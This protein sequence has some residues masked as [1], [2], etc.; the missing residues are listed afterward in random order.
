MLAPFLIRTVTLFGGIA[1][2]KALSKVLPVNP[3]MFK[4]DPIGT[5]GATILQAAAADAVMG[6]IE[7]RI[8]EGL[9]AIAAVQD[10]QHP[11]A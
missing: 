8:V 4:G 5:I 9:D 2:S 6:Y 10:E 11:S 1:V 7:N 3:E